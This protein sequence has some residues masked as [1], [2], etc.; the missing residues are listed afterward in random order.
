VDGRRL[1]FTVF[2]GNVTQLAWVDIKRPNEVVLIA[3][4]G[5]PRRASAVR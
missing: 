3:L 2:S 4:A 5:N 1:V